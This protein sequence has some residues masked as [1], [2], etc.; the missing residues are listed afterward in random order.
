VVGRTAVEVLHQRLPQ[1]KVKFRSHEASG[2]W[3]EHY[4]WDLVVVDEAHRLTHVDHPAI[5]PY[6]ALQAL[7]HSAE[8]LLLLSATPTTSHYKTH[9]G[10]LNL[11]DPNL[12]SW[13]QVDQFRE[14]FEKRIDLADSVYALD[15]QFTMYLASSIEDIR[16]VLGVRDPQFEYLSAQ[17][18]KLL[19]EDEDL[20][21]DSDESELTVRV[22]ELRAHISE[23][24]RLHRRVIRH[25]R[26]TV[27][28]EVPDSAFPS[29]EVRGRSIPE[30]VDLSSE[31]H[32]DAESFV[33]IGTAEWS[34]SDLGLCRYVPSSVRR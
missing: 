20:C 28:E 33:R 12:Y 32:D 25:R 13:E 4:G 27:L 5:E 14:R 26:A 8:K 9:L 18:L 10:L 34:M 22:E 29:Y 30:V 17:V 16:Q 21:D 6:P 24:Y 19:N 7:A 11:L 23:T 2:T 31:T 15:A 1:R 3:E